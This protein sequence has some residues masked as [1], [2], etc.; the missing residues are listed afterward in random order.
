MCVSMDNKHLALLTD[1]GVLWMGS[2]DMDKKY[3]EVN[4]HCQ[5]RAKQIVWWVFLYI[6][7][8]LFCIVFNNV[9]CAGV[10]QTL[11]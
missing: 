4:T 8:H 7:I 11:L 3:C 10:A 1:T 2:S 5:S 9:Y 6:S